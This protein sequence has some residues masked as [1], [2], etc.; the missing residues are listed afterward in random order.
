V[1]V[2]YIKSK[3]KNGKEINNLTA[4]SPKAAVEIVIIVLHI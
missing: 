3:G 1:H 2:L 4:V